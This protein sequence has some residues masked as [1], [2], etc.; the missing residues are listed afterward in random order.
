[1]D[2][3]DYDLES[4]ITMTDSLI[5]ERFQPRTT[6]PS[7]CDLQPNEWV[8]PIERFSLVDKLSAV[9][10]FYNDKCKIDEMEWERNSRTVSSFL[11]LILKAMRHEVR[12]IHGVTLGD[13]VPQGSSKEGLKVRHA[14]EF[15][16][17]FPIE[18]AGIEPIFLT[19]KDDRRNISPGFTEI[20]TKKPQ[21]TGL[22]AS[23]EKMALLQEVDGE[24]GRTFAINSKTVHA[25]IFRGILDKAINTITSKI[26]RMA[27][28][29]FKIEL[30]VRPP[31]LN[32]TLLINLAEGSAPFKIDMDVVPG[33]LI[34]QVP[35]PEAQYCR[36]YAVCCWMEESKALSQNTNITTQHL[37]TV[38]RISHAGFERYI[39]Y[40]SRETPASE[41]LCTACRILKC[42]KDMGDELSGPPLQI[43]TV[44]KS[45]HLKTILMY[46]VL[47]LV[48]IHRIEIRSVCEALAYLV[49]MLSS[50][51]RFRCLPSFFLGNICSQY[52]FNDPNSPSRAFYSESYR[53]DLF[54]KINVESLK[55]A[56]LSLPILFEKFEFKDVLNVQK[57]D[58][59]K[60]WLKEFDEH[61]AI[62][63]L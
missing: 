35:S 7:S 26:N 5:R 11:R 25:K 10:D 20:H 56:E 50:V 48:L 3:S 8:K 37:Q 27:S 34:D 15:D 30:I 9:Y 46:A 41:F 53:M 31:T 17:I 2:P 62:S 59:N 13:Y 33:I 42:L 28:V 19:H 12:N 51:L 45:Y 38:W 14:N 21:N 52:L 32:V 29:S 63:R 40:K 61:I 4:Y 57:P 22:S 60:K 47:Y 55:Q 43:Y 58:L 1:M 24:N 6:P 23:Y 44:I 18:I 16:A 54:R 39:I 36:R 49:E